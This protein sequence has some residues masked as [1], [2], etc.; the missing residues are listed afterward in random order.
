MFKLPT[1]PYQMDELKPNISKETLEFHYGKHHKAYVDNLNKL[2]VNTPHADQS[3]EM[4][5]RE[6]SGPIFNNAAQA[7]NHTFYWL[8]LTPPAT[9]A[10]SEPAGELGAAI[11][12]DFGSLQAMRDEFKASATKVFGSG[13]TW[14]IKDSKTGK[15]S[16]LNTSNADGPLKSDN[17]PV[18]VCDVW[19]HAY[20]VDYRNDRGRYFDCYFDAIDW[21]FA[22]E[23]YKANA[24]RE[25]TSVMK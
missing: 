24:A 15:L 18:V 5:V 4:I 20:Y 23:N 16:F 1:L 13:W 21:Q 9:R 6:S 22:E 3:L 8:G 7:W 14:L 2:I 17:V 11:K 19:E 25:L 10:K 12:K